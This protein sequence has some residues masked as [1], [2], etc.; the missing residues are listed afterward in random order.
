MKKQLLLFVL[1]F[2]S[3]ASYA[4]V[5]IGTTVPNAKSVLELSSTSKGLLLPRMTSGDRTSMALT[6]ADAGMM[7]YQ[8]NTPKGIYTFD[9]A[10]WIYHAPLDAGSSTSTTLRWDNSTSKW[11]PTGNL[12]NGG[13]S[14]GI[15][16][17][18]SPSSQLQIN[19]IGSSTRMHVTAPGFGVSS[20]DGLLL[21]MNNNLATMFPVSIRG[22]AYLI[23]QEVEPLWFGTSGVERMRI[24]SA[25]NVGINTATPTSTLDVNGSL[26]VNGTYK[27]GTS[28][29]PLNCIMRFDYEVDPPVLQP[30]GDWVFTVA[31]PGATLNGVV[32]VSP[33]ADMAHL[34][35][36]YARVK[37]LNNLEFKFTNMSASPS[38]DL[39]LIVLHIGLIQ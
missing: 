11:I 22:D 14:I 37:D 35:L 13:G 5:G 6:S 4:Q 23:Q 30:N 16:T 9:G 18:S 24:D 39:P 3:A 28:G 32:F 7:V 10:A 36:A 27:L 38:I 21:G 34:M 15:N 33:S 2:F 26:N 29:S 8:T 25:G 19:F 20:T 12:Y 1:A 31:C 17:G